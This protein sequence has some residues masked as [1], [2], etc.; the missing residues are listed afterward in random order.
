MASSKPIFSLASIS[1]SFFAHVFFPLIAKRL[2]FS[3]V[4]S[5]AFSWI[6]NSIWNNIS[7]IELLVFS[8]NLLHSLLHL[9]ELLLFLFSHTE[10]LVVTLDPSS[11]TLHLIHWPYLQTIPEIQPYLATLPSTPGLSYNLFEFK[12]SI[13]LLLPLLS[14]SH[15]MSQTGQYHLVKLK[16]NH[17]TF[18]LKNSQC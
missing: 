1:Q 18:L 15:A 13:V 10:G 14:T 9:I 8:P 2:K 17:F 12:F 16:S 5:W 7:K 11:L 6:F 4:S 3:R